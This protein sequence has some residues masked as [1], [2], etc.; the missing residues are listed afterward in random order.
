LNDASLR[1]K[2]PALFKNLKKYKMPFTVFLRKFEFKLHGNLIVT[3]KEAKKKAEE[4]AKKK[5]EEE[6]KRKAEEEA[7]RKA[8]EEAKQK[9]E[10]EAKRKAEEEAKKKAEAERM[11]RLRPFL[12]QAKKD[13]ARATKGSEFFASVKAARSKK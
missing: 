11:E 5:A 12:E 3:E 1:K 10:E 13:A 2:L 9:A 4:Q 6:A 7:T 8:E